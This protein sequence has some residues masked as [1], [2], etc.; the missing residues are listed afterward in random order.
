P[1]PSRAEQ[2]ALDRPRPPARGVQHYPA[3]DIP[4]LVSLR[5]ILRRAKA[6]LLPSLDRECQLSRSWAAA[7]RAPRAATPPPHRRARLGIF[8]VRC[9]L[10]CDPPVGGH[11]CNG[12]MIPRFHRA[13]GRCLRRVAARPLHHPAE[14]TGG[15][16]VR[17]GGSRRTAG[18]ARQS[19]PVVLCSEPA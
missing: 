12:G 18:T 11:S 6:R 10:P 13:K 16:E 7:A 5:A 4:P 9:N 15:S 3:L 8:V 2:Y 1:V 19:E 17:Y 14:P